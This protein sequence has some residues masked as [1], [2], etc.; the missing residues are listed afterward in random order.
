[1]AANAP[2]DLPRLAHHRAL[3]LG[4]SQ[5]PPS[6]H[7]AFLRAGG[8]D[9]AQVG[10][11]QIGDLVLRDV[12]LLAE[13]TE[14]IRVISETVIQYVGPGR[15][16]VRSANA[17]PGFLVASRLSWFGIEHAG[18]LIGLHGG[19]FWD[20]RLWMRRFNNIGVGPRYPGETR[21]NI[22]AAIYG[23]LGDQGMRE[24]MIQIPVDTPNLDA[25][26][27]TGW[28]DSHEI[29]F[30]GNAR[31]FMWLRR[32]FRPRRSVPAFPSSWGPVRVRQGDWRDLVAIRDQQ[33]AQW[34]STSLDHRARVAQS[35]PHLWG[36][37][38]AAV[39]L[40]DV[41]GV[42]TYGYLIRE[43]SDDPAAAVISSLHPPGVHREAAS[44][45]YAAL[46]WMAAAGYTTY[47]AY[48]R[49][50]CS[51]RNALVHDCL[52]QG[53]TL[54][55]IPSLGKVLTTY[56]LARVLAQPL[57]QYVPHWQ[58]LVAADQG[59]AALPPEFPPEALA[60]AQ[61]QREAVGGPR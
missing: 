9:A 51:G 32:A 13:R 57:A 18:R 26:H 19:C 61:A 4:S 52:A 2:D 21:P 43:A 30:Q 59:D 44:F 12:D 47:K 38:S 20:A 58:A 6:V 1:M 60:W 55:W 23:A 22:E 5:F 45:Y 37:E 53:G 24:A 15:L 25:R 17:V 41:D 39:L 49:P 11:H 33:L 29:H 42:P 35:I 3:M 28:Q 7:L 27:A 34:W 46:A 48:I 36:M 40:G 8:Q 10:T 50:D 56:P 16:T 54:T 31:P 14:V